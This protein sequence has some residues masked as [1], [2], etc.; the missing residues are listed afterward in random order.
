M[1]L[2]L[3]CD[4]GARFE[5]DD[6]WAGRDL[7]CPDCGAV[8]HAPGLREQ[9]PMERPSWL[10]LS[11]AA[12]VLFGAFTA[13]GTLAGAA[14]AAV[15]LYRRAAGYR[16]ALAAL[17]GG[18]VLTAFTLFA[19]RNPDAAPVGEWLRRQLLAG[20]IDT[21]GPD[22]LT[23][24][25]GAVTL[26]RPKGKWGQAI[27]NRLSDPAV[28][29]LQKDGELLLVRLGDRAFVDVRK[30]SGKGDRPLTEIGEL[31][32]AD[33]S[34]QPADADP[35]DPF[36]PRR[37]DVP[38]PPQQ[39]STRK[40]EAEDDVEGR[41]WVFEGQRGGARWR[42]LIRALRRGG[43][44]NAARPVYLVRAYAPVARFAAL[45]AELRAMLDGVKF[46]R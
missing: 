39:I 24:A 33:L 36:T 5:V 43:E 37:R 10:A 17:V 12:L 9:R 26:T 29:D 25:D 19:Y 1:S 21:A 11:A 2:T 13:V 30:V 42:F 22:D 6:V 18:V 40:L 31:I 23:S 14:V 15:A 16:L 35:A 46:T 20:Q 3:T 41:E 38:A 8:V 34:G 44:R 32:V 7:P 27:R 45:E 4:C 28:G